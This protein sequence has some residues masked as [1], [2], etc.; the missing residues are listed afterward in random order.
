[1]IGKV[2]S[3]GILLGLIERDG[4]KDFKEGSDLGY[5]LYGSNLVLF[6]VLIVWKWLKFRI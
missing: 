2:F 4:T 1:M 3:G 5:R 6:L